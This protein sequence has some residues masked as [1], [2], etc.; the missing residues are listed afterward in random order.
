MFNIFKK[1]SNQED[2]PDCW[3]EY[4]SHFE[5]KQDLKIPISEAKFVVLDVESNGLDPKNDK[6]LSIGALKIINN[7]IDVSNSFELFLDQTEFNPE[8]APIHGILKN[9]NIEKVSEQDAMKKLVKYIDDHIIVGHSIIFDISII[10]ETLSRYVGDKLLNKSLDTVNLYKRLKGADY[11]SGSSTSLDVLSDEFNI[12]KSD[13]HNAAGDALITA[14]L[15][16]KIVS[17]LKQRGI[18]SLEDLLR[19]KKTLF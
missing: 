9:G 18:D 14:I 6:I 13:R 10:N 7:Q 16:M 4:L 19:S 17:R 12:P 15:F 11:K 5:T 2:L 1:K 3:I 8:A